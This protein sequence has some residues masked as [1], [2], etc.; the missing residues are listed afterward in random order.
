MVSLTSIFLKPNPINSFRWWNFH[1]VFQVKVRGILMVPRVV[2]PHASQMCPHRLTGL[3][4]WCQ[5]VALAC[6]SKVWESG[7]GCNTC[8][9]KRRPFNSEEPFGKRQFW[10]DD[11][12][13][14]VPLLWI[15][16]FKQKTKDS[17]QLCAVKKRILWKEVRL[18][19][20]GLLL[21]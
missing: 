4:V 13:E 9:W 8:R 19:I 21:T 17:G 1:A 2:Y 20:L 5:W 3:A 11:D 14:K 12:W 10:V 16:R 6:Q 15:L 7:M 18:W